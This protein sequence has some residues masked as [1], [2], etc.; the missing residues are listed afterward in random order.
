[1]T[2]VLSHDNLRA[3]KPKLPS[4]DVERFRS[5]NA[6]RD[7]SHSR[8]DDNIL[9]VCA[10]DIVGSTFLN[11]PY[12]EPNIERPMGN[13]Q[14]VSEEDASEYV[15]PNL[16]APTTPLQGARFDLLVELEHIR[17][18]WPPDGVGQLT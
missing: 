10:L 5:R 3:P 6:K 7:N 2:E 12:E 18:G 1:M 4:D 11:T 17:L 13:E 15:A 8:N 9:E 14:E 16:I